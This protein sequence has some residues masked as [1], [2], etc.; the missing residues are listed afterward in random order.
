MKSKYVYV[1]GVYPPNHPELAGQPAPMRIKR[2]EAKRD[3]AQFWE[4]REECAEWLSADILRQLKEK[5]PAGTKQGDLVRRIE[6]ISQEAKEVARG[7]STNDWGVVE[8]AIMR[9]VAHIRG[10]QTPGFPDGG[11]HST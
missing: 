4:T 8:Q 9:V 7:I 10:L 6:V 5:F 3:G 2:T 11:F 1:V